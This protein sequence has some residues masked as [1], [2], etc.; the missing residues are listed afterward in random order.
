[1]T[2]RPPLRQIV[3]RAA[4][5]AVLCV[6]SAIASAQDAGPGAP[7]AP[8]AGPRAQDPSHVEE[9]T[10]KIEETAAPAVCTVTA[11]SE[12]VGLPKLRLPGLIIAPLPHRGPQQTEATAFYVSQD[13]HIVTTWDAVLGAS[14]FEVRFADGSVRD[15]RLLGGDEPFRLAVL[16]TM[17]P[18]DGATLDDAGYLAPGASAF[19]WLLGAAEERGPAAAQLTTV[20][21]ADESAGVYD[22]YLF[23]PLAL[24]TGGA[25]SP[26]LAGDGRLLGIAVGSCAPNAAAGADTQPQRRATLFVRGSDVMRAVAEIASVGRVRRA[27]L[28]VMLDGSSSRVDQLLPGSPA[29]R[30]GL[31]EGDVVT[32]IGDVPVETAADVTRTLL[33]RVPGETVDVAIRRGAAEVTQK[34]VLAE[35]DLP[36]LPTTAPVPG[37]VLEVGYADAAL[38]GDAPAAPNVTIAEIDPEGPWARA[39]A[40]PGDRVLSIDGG[41]ARRYLARHR[42]RPADLPPATLLVRRGDDLVTLTPRR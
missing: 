27:R 26:L 19:G 31:R 2:R 4:A 24:R 5:G 32:R 29:E 34:V 13:G 8:A 3:S 40:Q 16:R 36:E 12:Q 42:I 15:A 23:A 30:A 22:R 11:I 18:R 39:G 33:R 1:M 7:K 25:G 17:P 6:S 10:R 38:R 41:E 14:R 20:R 9:R 37:L 21:A 35:A 28:G